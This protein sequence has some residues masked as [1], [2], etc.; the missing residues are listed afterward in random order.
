MTTQN[1]KEF[2]AKIER[3]EISLIEHCHKILNEA[4]QAEDKNYFASYAGSLAIAQAKNVQQRLN[5]G[6]HLPLA[7]LPITVKDNICVKGIEATAGSKI[8]KG[9]RSVFNATAVQKLIDAGAIIIAK[10]AM[11]EFGFGSFGTNTGV[12]ISP[13]V[14]PLDN[15]RVCGGSS[16]GAAG[17]TALTKHN[18]AALAESTGGSIVNPASFCGVAGFC[19]TYG[20]VSRYGLIDYASSL[21]KIGTITKTANDASIILQTIAGHDTSDGTSSNTNVPDYNN[22]LKA[23]VNKLRIGIVQDALGIGVDE[24]IQQRCSQ[25]TKKLESNGVIIEP[26]TLPLTLKFGISTYYLLAL[27]EASTNLAKLCGMRYGI[28]ENMNTGYNEYFTRIR[29]ANF[30]T[31][32][33]R[34]IILGTFARMSGYRDALYI[35]AA[36][37]RNLIL[38][39]YARAFKNVD[40]LCTPT[41]P[42]VAPKFTEVNKLTPNQTYASDILTVGPNLAGLP[43]MSIPC[44]TVQKLPSGIMFTANHFDEE[45]LFK[46]GGALEHA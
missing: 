1:I 43:H 14:H 31:E 40:A 10:T 7:G 23:G 9:Y 24:Q 34:R 5:A 42:F 12:G 3:G 4:V 39:E 11:D 2:V 38:Q 22:A 15:T 30:G 28:Q 6:E 8:L 33:K 44:G 46:I 20:R 41:M 45:T 36:K 27:A 19:P 32:A 16:S 37:V 26:V 29:S 35:R 13:A 25:V 18:H 17:W 21:D